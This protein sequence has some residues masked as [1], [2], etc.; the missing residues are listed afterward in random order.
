MTNT[1]A[2]MSFLAGTESLDFNQEGWSLHR[3]PPHD[4]DRFFR[5]RVSF[6]RAF[7][8]VPLVHVGMTGLD[9]SNLDAVRVTV[10]ASNITPEGFEIAVSTWLDSRVWRVGV[11]WLAIG[12]E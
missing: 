5:A 11:S 8:G 6:A 12:P 2:P 1:V 3:E 4:A 9:A 10:S 7:R